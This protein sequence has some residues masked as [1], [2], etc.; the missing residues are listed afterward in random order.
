[1]ATTTVDLNKSGN[2]DLVLFD[3]MRGRVRSTATLSTTAGRWLQVSP[4]SH[5]LAVAGGGDDSVTLWD[6]TDPEHPQRLSI[7]PAQL[8]VLDIEFSP[9][10]KVLALST[11][12]TVQLWD[13]H[14]PGEPELLGSITTPAEGDAVT[15]VTA[16]EQVLGVAFT[17]QGDTLA[18][19][20]SAMS[21]SLVDSDPAQLAARLCGYA[22][23]PIS[24]AQWQQ[25]AP[26]VPYRRPCP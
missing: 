16:D 2:S 18:R 21:T 8:G 20:T 12:A 1:M 15:N 7:V 26:G 24:P 13:I 14:N 23:A 9:D 25:D 10:G 11:S 5:L 19:S 22:A 6:I 3:V 17:G 4:A